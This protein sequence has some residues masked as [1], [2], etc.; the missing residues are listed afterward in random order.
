MA[1]SDGLLS[2]YK[3]GY[4]GIAAEKQ[5]RHADD[6][7]AVRAREDASSARDKTAAAIQKEEEELPWKKND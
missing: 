4:G 6:A 5:E 2:E 1:N 3:A 7:L